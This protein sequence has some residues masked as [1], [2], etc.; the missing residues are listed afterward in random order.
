MNTQRDLFAAARSAKV[1]HLDDAIDSVAARLTKVTED[2]ALASRILASLPERSAW[3]LRWLIPRLAMTA[4]LGIGVALVVRRPF[5]DRSTDVLRT[6]NART[7]FVE[8]RAVVERTSVE[9]L[10]IVRRTI[11]ERSENDRR[12]TADHERSLGAIAAPASLALGALAPSDLPGQGVLVVAP[13]AIEELPL[14]A[15]TISPR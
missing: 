11:V 10:Q 2:D 4:A 15:E 5:D 13:L 6:E 9:P 14:T 8:F 1:D 3:S 7:P 12:T